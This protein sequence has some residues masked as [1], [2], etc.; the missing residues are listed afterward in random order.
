MHSVSSA[1]LSTSTLQINKH[2]PDVDTRDVRTQYF[3]WTP[4]H[5]AGF[6]GHSDVACVLLRHAADVHV[7][8]CM[9][10]TPIGS[11]MNNR[12]VATAQDM[13]RIVS[14][15]RIQGFLRRWLVNQTGVGYLGESQ[16][17]MLDLKTS[18]RFSA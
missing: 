13:R 2:L 16:L 6:C 7:E 1:E 11:A 17:H 18:S 4:L 10:L 5:H 9:G 3:G 8:D 14:L 12:Q 15:T